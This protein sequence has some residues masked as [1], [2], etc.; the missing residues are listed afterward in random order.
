MI[1]TGHNNMDTG[2]NI[3]LFTIEADGG[4]CVGVLAIL[5]SVEDRCLAAA[6]QPNHDTVISSRGAEGDQTLE[7]LL[8][9]SCS[10]DDNV[11]LVFVY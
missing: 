1:G 8:A 6:I 2:D 5:E 11:S 7:R 9:H 3:Y 4:H 10:H